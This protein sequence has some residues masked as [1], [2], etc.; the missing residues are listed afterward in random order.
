MAEPFGQMT[1]QQ[2]REARLQRA[3]D[4]KVEQ[5][6]RLAKRLTMLYIPLAVVL[7][8]VAVFGID[9]LVSKG[10]IHGG[11][12]VAGIKLGGKTPAQAKTF[13]DNALESYKETPITVTWEKKTWDIKPTAI[14][15][16]FNTEDIVSQAYAIGRG[17]GLWADIKDRWSCWFSSPITITLTSTTDDDA[18]NKVLAPLVKAIDRDPVDSKVEF[19]DGSFIAKEGS[20][21]RQLNQTKL[22]TALST[23]V[24]EKATEVAAPVEVVP[25]EVKAS[26]AT[27]AANLANQVIGEDVR[28]IYKDKKWTLK[29]GTLAKLLS[30]I[31]SD[32]LADSDVALPSTAASPTAGNIAL[33]VV[34]KPKT[35]EK[36]VIPKLGTGVGKSPVD[37]KFSVSGGRVKIKPSKDGT[38]ADPARLARDIVD[39]CM[40]SEKTERIVTVVTTTVKPKLTTADAEALGITERISRYTTTYGYNAPRVNN[41]KLLAK[42]LN[43]TLVAPGETFSFNGTIGER[44]AAKGY[45]EAGAIV[46]GEL[47]PQL[48]G[49]ICQVNTTL[50][51]ATLL[52]GV[53]ITERHNHS[54]YISH[55]P[56]GRDATVSWGGPDFKFK[57]TLDHTILIAAVASNSSVTVSFWGVDP[58]Y[59]VTLS[60]GEFTRKDFKTKEI[61]D[62]DLE[63]GK[64]SVETHGI[65]GGQVVLTQTV[66]K[67]GEVVRKSTYTSNYVSVTEVVRVGTKKPKEKKPETTEDK[68][69]TQGTGSQTPVENSGN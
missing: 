36:L 6:R 44:T 65:K 59:K 69:D 47:V 16:A 2:Y 50:F 38:G 14:G 26:E 49:G 54:Y 21:G 68:T 20:D 13:L 58:G 5:R 25:M 48:G 56:L 1:A 11:V 40:H 57:N 43:G 8:V 4:R 9:Y 61:K 24:L 10:K 52:S 51:N 63:K 34:V 53:E 3:H 32:K 27:E 60:T 64:K 66:K 23:A 55:Y 41:I 19:S 62:P 17:S 46:N 12:E 42:S 31:R 45:K 67:D 33:A 22:V 37:A 35:V 15:L 29:S 28:V 30:F 39:A 7:L 18:A